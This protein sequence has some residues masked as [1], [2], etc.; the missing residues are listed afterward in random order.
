METT[1]GQPPSSIGGIPW[2]ASHRPRK[3]PQ[4]PPLW[5]VEGDPQ[6]ASLLSRERPLSRLPMAKE[7]TLVVAS[8]ACWGQPLGRYPQADWA[9]LRGHLLSSFMVVLGL[10]SFNWRGCSLG[11]HRFWLFYFSLCVGNILFRYFFVKYHSR[12]KDANVCLLTKP[13]FGP[14]LIS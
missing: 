1:L 4:W 2:V 9:A 14:L 5:L 3:R 8:L 12:D 13:S 7:A 6:A 11:Q 10:F